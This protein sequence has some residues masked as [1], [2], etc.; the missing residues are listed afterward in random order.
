VP[1]EGKPW[2]EKRKLDIWTAFTEVFT[3][4]KRMQID[5]IL[6]A[7]DLFHR[8][9]LIKELREIN[10]I[11]E[12]VPQIKIVI[13]AGHHDFLSVNSNY[14]KFS[15][16][17]NVTFL[18]K[19]EIES[20]YYP[21]LHTEVYGMSYWH[22]EE[23]GAFYDEVVPQNREAINILMAHGGDIKHIPFQP[24][25]ILAHGF[26]Y[27]AGGHIH[28]GGI[29]EGNSV[30]P[31]PLEGNRKLTTM[32][33]VMAGALEP[34]DS[35]DIGEHGFWIGEIT[36]SFVQVQFCPLKHCQY[37]HETI[38]VSPKMTNMAVQTIVNNLLENRQPYELYK[39]FLEGSSH[40]DTEIDLEWIR[41]Q[42]AVVDVISSLKTDYNY[43]RLR[44]QNEDSLLG[45]FILTMQNQGDS[46]VY[47]KALQVGV[48][49]LLNNRSE[50]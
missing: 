45:R 36:K 20:V 13:I 33:A 25:K 10:Y 26:D 35:N 29:L 31:K 43:D 47:R 11:F 19:N 18:G 3:V 39:I 42:K 41:Q 37:I 30:R 1:D 4:A 22:R 23:T 49:A 38:Q 16:A 28:R 50:I 17:K 27:L 44:E 14:R 8:Q 32:R 46:Q 40:V 5:L 24:D 2:S 34:I 7:G 6:I 48:E 12:Q 15:F 9:P 21:D